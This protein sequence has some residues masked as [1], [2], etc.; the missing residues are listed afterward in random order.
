ML[1]GVNVTFDSKTIE[2]EG[3]GKALPA[4]IRNLPETEVESAVRL[5]MGKPSISGLPLHTITY[6]S[7]SHPLS[8]L[9]TSCIERRMPIKLL[10]PLP[11]LWAL[12]SHLGTFPYSLFSFSITPLLPNLVGF[13]NVLLYQQSPLDQLRI[14]LYCH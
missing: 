5:A 11:L 7:S 3:A 6:P 4:A 9:L 1:L 2:T 12:G 13:L 8:T 14:V 10:T